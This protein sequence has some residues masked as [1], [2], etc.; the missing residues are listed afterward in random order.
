[1]GKRYYSHSLLPIPHSPPSTIYI[2]QYK[3]YAAQDRQQI[4]DHRAATDQRYHLHM[5]KRRSS[6]A[7]AVSPRIAVADQVIAVVALGRFN[8]YQR[9]ARRNHRPPAHAKKMRDQRLDV[10]HRAL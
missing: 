4:G 8:V 5:R 10:M 7:Y 2:S 3:I 9:L 1:M 6:D